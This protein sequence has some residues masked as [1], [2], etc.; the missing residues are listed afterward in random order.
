MV[1]MDALAAGVAPFLPGVMLVPDL[2]ILL[3]DF[4]W[5]EGLEENFWTA[6]DLAPVLATAFALPF[7]PPATF[8][9]EGDAGDL[10][11]AYLRRD[12]VFVFPCLKFQPSPSTTQTP[13]ETL[14][15]FPLTGAREGLALAAAC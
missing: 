15:L 14:P 9:P 8:P 7:T 12:T 11:P 13:C 3:T 6:E 10:P 2:E 5:T 1:E 4:L